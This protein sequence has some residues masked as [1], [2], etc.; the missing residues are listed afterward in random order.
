MFTMNLSE[1]SKHV[2]F[3]LKSGLTLITLIR[4]DTEMTVHMTLQTVG[5]IKCSAAAREGTLV[6]LVRVRLVEVQLMTDQLALVSE[7]FTTGF[8]GNPQVR[9]SR[10]VSFI[11]RGA[12][13][14]FATVGADMGVIIVNLKLVSGLPRLRGEYQVTEPT[15]DVGLRS[16][17]GPAVGP[18]VYLHAV[19]VLK[20]QPTER[21]GNWTTSGVGMGLLMQPESPPVLVL[22]IT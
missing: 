10:Q 2:R 18:L 13:E 20:T 7:H 11:S 5:L 6:A 14:F 22:F 19:T 17:P 16:V 4:L 9:V 3:V 12:V 8:A 15:L 21:T 1:M